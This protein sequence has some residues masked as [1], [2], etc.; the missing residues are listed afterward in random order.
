MFVE[1]I[2]LPFQGALPLC[3]VAFGHRPNLKEA[4]LS[5]RVVKKVLISP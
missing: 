2:K 3:D 1:P 4:G 5:A